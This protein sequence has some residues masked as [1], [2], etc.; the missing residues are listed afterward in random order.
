MI[1]V[2]YGEAELSCLAADFEA[3]WSLG[4]SIGDAT[5]LFL[6]VLFFQATF[7]SCGGIARGLSLGMSLG[8]PLCFDNL[9]RRYFHYSFL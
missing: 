5:M 6:G 9:R 1:P 3:S 2:Y 8:Y 7:V 4:S